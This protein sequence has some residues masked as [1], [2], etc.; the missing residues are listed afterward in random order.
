MD[1]DDVMLT[2]SGLWWT[3]YLSVW[4]GRRRA[5]CLVVCLLMPRSGV[6]LFH[7]SV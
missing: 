1:Y 3:A 4:M 5:G 7:A 2:L 6:P